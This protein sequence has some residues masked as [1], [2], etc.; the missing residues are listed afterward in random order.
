MA[1]RKGQQ[2]R[3]SII[4]LSNSEARAFF[5]KEE[6]YCSFNLP[7]YFQFSN[8]LKDT[9]KILEG[10]QLSDFRSKA[11]RIPQNSDKVNH[12]IL[13]N[14]DGRY[15]WRPLEL[16]HPALYISLVNEIT[17]TD[18]WDL[19]RNRFNMFSQNPKIACLS[20][21]IESMTSEKDKAELVSKW[22]KDVEQKS[23]EL[24]LDYD[25]MIQTDI[26]DC[27]PTIYTHSIAWAL[28][29]KPC[30][31]RYRRTKSLIGNIIDKHIQ[32]MRQG[33]T[34]GIPQGSALMDLIAEMVLGYADS[35]LTGKINEKGVEKYQI[36]RYRDDYRIFVRTRQDGEEILKCLT[37]VMIDLGLKMNP[38]KTD[39]SSEIIRSS[40]K[41]DKL[42]W[43]F[44]K[45]SDQNLQKR[46][47]MIH[48]HSI[49]YIN[50]GSL[51]VAL[52][53][54]HK[55][56]LKTKRYDYPLSLISIV[57]DIVYRNPRTYAISSAILSKLISLL[58]TDEEKRDV[59]EKIRRKFCQLP[60]T[61]QMDIWLQRISRSFAPDSEFD[62]PLCKL[63]YQ[64]STSIWNSDWISSP[65][66]LKAV[67]VE[68]I[69]N[70]KTLEEISPIIYDEEVD[71]F[72]SDY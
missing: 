42:N 9:S 66:L 52:N 68:K 34:N 24:A 3:R 40:I 56:L 19:I 64:K 22:W 12:V 28:H 21:P 60:N 27:Y 25:F 57:A 72:K 51:E 38:T 18:Y 8:L 61:G 30:A 35:E 26:T 2:R 4:E 44:R 17:K 50:S 6:S 59:I 58:K 67:E 29:S 47:L 55:L 46:L 43:M 33:Q 1:K 13:N 70:W 69:I 53:R 65:N 45:Q 54:Y 71:L 20:L 5:L 49:K 36:L 16:I 48:D 37:E 41:E 15:A 10:K 7:K 11:Q 63:V 62:E 39:I 31:K 32:D 23:I 14:K